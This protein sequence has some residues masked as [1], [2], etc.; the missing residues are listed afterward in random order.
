MLKNHI[1]PPK[2]KNVSPTL[3]IAQREATLRDLWSNRAQLSQQQWAELYDQVV[4][5]LRRMCRAPELESI[6]DTREEHIQQFFMDRVFDAD[7]SKLSVPHHFGA[8]C[9][10]FRNF[11]KDILKSSEH[12]QKISLDDCEEDKDS[13]IGQIKE[14]PGQ[15]DYTDG[16]LLEVGLNEAKVRESAAE[17]LAS[18]EKSDQLY[19]ACHSCAEHEDAEPLSSMAK[20]MQI[21]SYHHRALKLGITLKKGESEQ[22]YEKTYIGTWLTQKLKLRCTADFIQENLVALKI[23]CDES[24]KRYSHLCSGGK[25]EGRQ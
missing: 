19:L 6:S 3:T 1:T 24:L 9:D 14:D 18:L 20:R 12:K 22:G 25:A 15:R 10:W 7:F 17:F 23:L 5:G 16:L 13:A 2:N 8:L 4:F 21:A 11:L